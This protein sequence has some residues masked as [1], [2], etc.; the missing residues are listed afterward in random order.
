LEVKELL[1]KTALPGEY[2]QAFRTLSGFVKTALER[3]PTRGDVIETDGW[4]FEV[5]N[6]T[7]TESIQSS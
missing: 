2:E 1:G 7:G 3:V 6:W 4:R 5:F